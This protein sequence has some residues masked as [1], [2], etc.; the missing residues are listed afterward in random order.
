MPAR[1]TAL[2]ELERYVLGA[3]ASGTL[4]AFLLVVR[5]GLAPA[6]EPV[7]FALLFWAWFALLHLAAGLGLLVLALGL[8]RATRRDARLAWPRR[9]AGPL[10]VGVALAGN[11][12]DF[13]RLLRLPGPERFRW[14]VPAALLLAALALLAAALLPLARSRVP[15]LLAGLAALAGLGAGWPARPPGAPVARAAAAVPRTQSGPDRRLLFLGLDGAD[16]RYMEPLI[17]RGELPHLAALRARGAWAELATA[18][19]TLSPVIW[20]TIATGLP[21]EQHGIRSFTTQ[22]LAGARAALPRLR[23]VR[24]V[25]FDTLT[26]LLWKRGALFESPITQTSRR[27]PAFWNIASALGSPVDVLNWWATWPAEPVLGR[28]VSERVHYFRFSVR[29][30]AHEAERLT[31]PEGLYREIAPLVMDPDAVSYEQ[32]R[33]FLDVSPEEF[34]AMM[35]APFER[36]SIRGE[37][38]YLFSLHETERRLGRYLLESSRKAHGAPTDLL[39]LSRIVDMACHTSLRHS[40]LV[41]HHPRATPEELRKYGRV[42]TEA[43]KAADRTLGALLEAFGDGNVVV[44]SDHGFQIE[45][46][47]G[48]IHVYDHREAPPG[49]LIAAGPAFRPGRVEGLGVY[50]VLP[51]LLQLKGF[52]QAEDLPGRLATELLEASFLARHPV[53]RVASYRSLR[54]GAAAPPAEGAG[55]DE[56]MERL[57]A[58]GYVE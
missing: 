21:P 8:A 3:L 31:H 10:V 36:R 48:R 44:V 56:L 35:H 58:L 52:A 50:D 24:G 42:V 30:L 41:R 4:A 25:G 15:R 23:R 19:P 1:P 27:V 46:M 57:R 28:M 47:Q 38:K 5:N 11:G 54:G 45:V 33:V 55:D 2:A 40:E 16:W 14:L 32:A 39:V 7:S 53:R 18:T 49:I 51:L 12:R 26:G 9:L 29:G 34:Q 20:T 22:R 37:F 17:A 13:E 43:Y 6:Q